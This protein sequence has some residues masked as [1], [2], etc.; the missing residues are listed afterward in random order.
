MIR[1]LFPR[2]EDVR[3]MIGG[4]HPWLRLHEECASPYTGLVQRT[5]I[6]AY[7]KSDHGRC[8]HDD[9]DPNVLDDDDG[10]MKPHLCI[11]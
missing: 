10:H 4:S 2:N 7:S 1:S 3:E 9:A 6:Q 8:H 5:A 11:Q